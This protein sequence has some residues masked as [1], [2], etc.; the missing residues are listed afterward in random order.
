[1]SSQQKTAQ[2]HNNKSDPDQ[3][4]KVIKVFCAV[5]V[6]NACCIPLRGVVL[7]YRATGRIDRM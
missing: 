3:L 7:A 6:H 5:R 4:G 1:V 2:N